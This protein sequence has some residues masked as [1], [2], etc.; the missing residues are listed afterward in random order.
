MP[1]IHVVPLL[2]GAQGRRCR[3]RKILGGGKSYGENKTDWEV[4]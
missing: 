1:K 4:A 2:L 3:N